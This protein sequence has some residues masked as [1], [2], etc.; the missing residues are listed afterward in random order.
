MKKLIL[1]ASI[2][3]VLTP[4]T[5]FAEGDCDDWKSQKS[6]FFQNWSNRASEDVKWMDEELSNPDLPEPLRKV[7]GQMKAAN[8]KLPALIQRG[9]AAVAADDKKAARLAEAEI[10]T[11]DRQLSLLGFE[12]HIF[13]QKQELKDWQEKLAADASATALVGTAMQKMDAQLALQ[14]K[15][16]E[17]NEQNEQLSREIEDLQKQIKIKKLDRERAEL[18]K[19]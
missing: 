15:I 2:A 14:G 5:T 11:L 1:L 4:L 6:E 8:E 16:H 9:Q 7:I 13:W 12:K 3:L 10:Q 19:E 18:E 17:L